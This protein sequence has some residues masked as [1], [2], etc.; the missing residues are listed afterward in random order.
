MTGP[1]ALRPVAAVSQPGASE[2]QLASHRDQI[3]AWLHPDD[4]RRGLRLSKVHQLLK[5]QGVDVPYSSLH[6]Y[7]VAHCGFGERRRRTVWMAETRPGEVAEVDNFSRLSFGTRRGREVRSPSDCRGSS[8]S[9]LLAEQRWRVR[10][11]TF[12][13]ANGSLPLTAFPVNVR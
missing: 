1:P 9:R 8:T 12:R 3:H 13:L 5:R 10:V 4:E 11:Q 7:A 2:A 6:R